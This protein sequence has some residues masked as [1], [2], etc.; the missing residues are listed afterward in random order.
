[1]AVRDEDE[2]RERFA[3]RYGS[4][5]PPAALS[6]ERA[7]YDSDYGAVGATTRAQA[8]HLGQVLELGPDDRLLD[9]GSGCGW[10]GVY[11]AD[12]TGCSVVVT[13]LPMSGMRRALDRAAADGL[14][15]RTTAVVASARNLPFRPDCFDAI[16][17]TD[18][19]C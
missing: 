19:L 4:V 9:I 10:P 16:V 17:H 5:R 7:V 15:G 6:V 12:T 18:V 1:V 14:A 3:E 13:D 8:D 2:A 11:L